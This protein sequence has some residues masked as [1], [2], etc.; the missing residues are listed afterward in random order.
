ME[1]INYPVIKHHIIWLT[2]KLVIRRGRTTVDVA[3]KSRFSTP[4]RALKIESPSR[5]VSN[6]VPPPLQQTSFQRPLQ[7]QSPSIEL[8]MRGSTAGWWKSSQKNEKK[9]KL[10]RPLFRPPFDCSHTR[11]RDTLSWRTL[12]GLVVLRAT[13]IRRRRR[14]RG[15]GIG[16]WRPT[17]AARSC[18]VQQQLVTF[19]RACSFH[20]SLGAL[21]KVSNLVNSARQGYEQQSSSVWWHSTVPEWRVWFFLF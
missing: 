11:L 14:R 6:H 12:S 4:G 9:Q 18:L 5:H 8:R 19:S 2:R 15:Q 16:L 13:N 10:I 20:T 1:V 3:W 17:W 7:I 21:M